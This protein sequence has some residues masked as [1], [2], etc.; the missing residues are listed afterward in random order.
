MEITDALNMTIEAVIEKAEYFRSEG[1]DVIDIGC[2]P[3][4][5]FPHLE[6]VGPRTEK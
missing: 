2:L 4:K 3:N 6:E 1:A 5:E